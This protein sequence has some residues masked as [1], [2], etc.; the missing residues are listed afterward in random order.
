M[1]A[2]YHRY[3]LDIVGV[4]TPEFTF[5]QEASNVRQAIAADGIRYPVVQDNRYGTWNAYHNQ[6]WPAE[7]FID[8]S[9]SVRHIKFGEG[10]YDT[11][12]AVIR[13]LLFEAGARRLPPPVTPDAIVPSKGLATPETYVDPERASAYQEKW[14]QPLRSG[15][16]AYHGTTRPAINEFSLNG[17]WRLDKQSATAVAPGA[18]ISGRFQAQHVYLVL[19]SAGA[20]P[21]KVTVLLDGRPLTASQAGADV[22]DGAVTVRGQRLYSLVSAPYDETATITVRLPPGV[23]AYDFTFG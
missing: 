18:S 16:H 3:G 14:S 11:D 8:A 21:R 6:Y 7:Y 2:T 12:E 9:G 10:G 1:Y 19:T 22:R 13:Q 4:E 20:V 23:S 17:T 15:T 5:E